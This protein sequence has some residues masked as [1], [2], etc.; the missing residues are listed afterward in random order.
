MSRLHKNLGELVLDSVKN[1]ADHAALSINNQQFSYQ[2]LFSYACPLITELQRCPSATAVIFANKTLESYLAIF[3][4]VLAGKTYMP[5]APQVGAERL[6][7]MLDAINAPLIMISNKN[8]LFLLKEIQIRVKYQLSI[9]LLD[10]LVNNKEYLSLTNFV[11]PDNPQAYIMFTSG[12]TGK[13][14]AVRVGQQQILHYLTQMQERYM[15]TISDRFSQAIE[16]TFDLSVHDIFLCW[17]AGS[18][19]YP[20]IGESYLQLGQYLEENRL[21]FWLSVPST[22]IGLDRVK[23]LKS[24]RFNSLRV[25]LFCGEPLSNEIVNKWS[26]AA[27]GAQVENI[28]GP[29]EA[30]VAFT[31]YCWK[32]PTE[33]MAHKLV[34]IG[35]PLPGLSTKIV[36]RQGQECTGNDIGELWLAG[37]QIVDGYLNNPLA[38]AE[39]FVKYQDDTTWYRSGDLV[40]KDAHGDLHFK[41]RIDDQLQVRGERV[42]RLELEIQFKTILNISQLVVIP[43]PV[44]AE[45]IVLGIALIYTGSNIK[46]ESELRRICQC[47]FAAH[48]LPTAYHYIK[49]FPVLS[50]GKIH[51]K[52][53]LKTYQQNAREVV[54]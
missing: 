40:F 49:E 41:G 48:F 46:Q 9:I 12:S 27:S 4:C 20:F 6:M 50:N 39:K 24:K 5:V 28:Y 7:E 35:K 32:G 31:A 30:T 34:P 16:L 45:G 11:V 17:S 44:T 36:D 47:H 8:N 42:E 38:T 2:D 29:T 10:K 13:P 19:L 53:L 26:I 3:A 18:C 52:W 54:S 23:Q 14:K 43:S 33:Y 37:P 21:T 22:V 51:Y 25:S 1:F 15:P